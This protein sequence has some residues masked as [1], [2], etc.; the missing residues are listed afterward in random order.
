MSLQDDFLHQQILENVI[1]GN[2][3]L[4]QKLIVVLI[5]SSGVRGLAQLIR[6]EIWRNGEGAAI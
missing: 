2:F 5:V 6:G 1:C 4:S 3:F